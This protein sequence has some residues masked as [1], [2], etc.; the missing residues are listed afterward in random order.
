MKN[1]TNILKYR[2]L[3]PVYDFFVHRP[4]LLK[5]RARA[6]RLLSLRPGERV[7]IIGVGTGEDLPFVP[8]G[9]NVTGIDLSPDMLRRA[10]GKARGRQAELLRM[11][12]ERLAFADETFDAVVL[13]LILAI[14]EHPR[15]AMAEALR[16]A[17]PSG[18][19]LVFD[20][21]VPGPHPSLGRRMLNVLTSAVATDITRRFDDIVR[22]MPVS[23]KHDEC[24]IAG[25]FFRV[26]LLEKIAEPQPVA[27]A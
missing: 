3:A 17:K 11:N 16:V 13:N 7:L 10:R 4:L 20:K 9:V 23:V 1:R 19:L 18:R 22:G 2:L 25:C 24:A 14:V 26:I 6:F 15:A 8:A 12:A 27:P 5:T 21:F